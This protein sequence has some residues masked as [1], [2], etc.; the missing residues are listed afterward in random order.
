MPA[1]PLV[2]FSQFQALFTGVSS[3]R[4]EAL[5]PYFIDSL[6]VASINTCLRISAFVAQIGHESAGLLFFEETVDGS[7][8]EGRVDLGNTQPGDGR[9]FKGRGPIQLT[10]RSNYE[11]AARSLGRSF[12]SRPEEVAMP[13]GGFEA[14][15][16]FWR[17][18]VG[19]TEADKGTR[20]GFDRTTIA[21]NGCGGVITRC[22]GVEDRRSRW[23]NAKAL[24]GC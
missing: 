5:Y 16:W 6:G 14:T 24:L 13:S 20:D 11:N 18:R 12:T 22:N 17:T 1:S 19:N 8:Y 10:G 21:I 23:A 15:A 2:S 9:R 7:Q 4:A 3:T